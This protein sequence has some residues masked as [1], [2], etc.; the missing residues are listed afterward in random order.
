MGILQ[1]LP[2][3]AELRY[4]GV[5]LKPVQYLF[6]LNVLQVSIYINVFGLA[7]ILVS[8]IFGCER[9]NSKTNICAHIFEKYDMWGH[10]K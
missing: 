10:Q 6:N 1:I 9:V 8:H 4:V 2:I 7:V 5:L 3:S